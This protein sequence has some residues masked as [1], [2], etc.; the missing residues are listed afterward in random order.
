[1]TCPNEK[2]MFAAWKN[3]TGHALKGGGKFPEVACGSTLTVSSDNGQ[4]DVKVV[5]TGPG[6]SDRIIDLSLAA[7]KELADPAQKAKIK[8]CRS[9]GLGD[10]RG[11]LKVT[12]NKA[13]AKDAP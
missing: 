1:M 7:A 10:E 13:A 2:D 5:D 12:V 4:V 9:S 11:N 8:S 6:D 3:V